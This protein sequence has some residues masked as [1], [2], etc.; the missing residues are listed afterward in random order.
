MSSPLWIQNSL[1]ILNNVRD[2]TPDVFMLFVVSWFQT[3]DISID[4]FIIGL[5]ALLFLDLLRRFLILQFGRS[6]FVSKSHDGSMSGI[7]PRISPNLP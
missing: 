6:S 4:T 5:Q 1:G 2:Q 3:C 7:F